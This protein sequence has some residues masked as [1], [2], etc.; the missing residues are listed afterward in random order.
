MTVLI[1]YARVRSALAAIRSLGRRKISIIAADDRKPST[2]F[3]SKYVNS[4]FIYPSYKDSPCEFIRCLNKNVER[5]N[6][7]IIMPIS[8]ETY[9]I[10]K[11]RNAIKK[12]KVPVPDYNSI[13]LANNKSKLLAFADSL[14]IN[15]PQTYRV[16]KIEELNEI[17]QIIEYP[18][19]IKLIEGRGS[20]GLRYVHSKSELINEYKHTVKRFNLNASNYPLIQQY[21]SG[22]GFGVSMLFN[23]GDARASFTHKR[24]REYPMSG[25]PSTARISV[26]Y[27]EI[28][29]FAK[30]LLEE[31]NWHGVAMV[32][33]KYDEFT[34][35]PYL[36]EVNPRFWGSLNQAIC[37][38]VDFPYLLYKMTLEGDVKPVFKYKQG[39]ETRWMLGDARTILDYIK[40]KDFA[41][42]KNFLNFYDQ[43]LYYDDIVLDDPLPT[44]AEVMIPILNYVRKGRLSFSPEEKR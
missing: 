5:K 24:I 34:K 10:S 2:S 18:A 4:H 44:I 39:I 30:N 6:I 16:E 37:A 12:A 40:A 41:M 3:Y 38:G 1:T 23:Q 13:V 22:S 9:V 17:S 42:V 26:K 15:V 33:F 35:K 11:Y 36:L 14:G 20:K 8:E 7:D 29:K 19:V 43:N 21:L 27:P 31:L 28:E 25:G 32:E